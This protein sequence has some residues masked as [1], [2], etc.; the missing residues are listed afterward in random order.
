MD[1]K[2]PNEREEFARM[3]HQASPTLSCEPLIVVSTDDTELVRDLLETA[4][5]DLGDAKSSSYRF[6][7]HLFSIT[8][9]TAILSLDRNSLRKIGT[10]W[11]ISNFPCSLTRDIR[12]HSKENLASYSL[13][14]WKMIIIQILAI[15][16]MH[17]LFKRLGEWTFWA[18]EWKGWPF[19]SQ[20]WSISNFPCSLTRD[21][22]S[23]SMRNLA[24]HKLPFTRISAAV[25]VK[26][27]VIRVRRLL[28]GGAHLRYHPG[29]N[30]VMLLRRRSAQDFNGNPMKVYIFWKLRR[31][32]IR[33]DVNLKRGT[34]YF[35]IWGLCSKNYRVF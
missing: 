16:L 26:I 35:R 22:R 10:E 3:R 20:E 34:K 29:V 28:D 33:Q 14:R 7:R 21:I 11:S 23:H 25:L 8:F 12:S 17:F 6:S 31:R 19:H 27:S 18:Q 30:H 9:A 24:F 2:S 13:L 4:S 1:N 15:S 32:R 5:G